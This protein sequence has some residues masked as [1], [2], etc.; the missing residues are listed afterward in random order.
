MVKVNSSSPKPILEP[1]DLISF[2][3]FFLT[4]GSPPV[5]LIFFVPRFINEVHRV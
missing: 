3:T 4:S 2:K 1:R 5:S